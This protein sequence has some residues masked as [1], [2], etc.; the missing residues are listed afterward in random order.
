MIGRLLYPLSVALLLGAC[1]D[2]TGVQDPPPAFSS[3][4]QAYFE[5]YMEEVNPTV[6]VV[7]AD[8]RSC[9]GAAGGLDRGCRAVSAPTKEAPAW[10]ARTPGSCG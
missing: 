8:V 7:S 10:L 1:Q 2:A 9:P 5:Q 4:V 3:D 6:F